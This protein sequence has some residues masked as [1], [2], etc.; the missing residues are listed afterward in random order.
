[1]A[2]ASRKGQF[3]LDGKLYKLAVNNGAHALHGGLKGFD[4]VVWGAKEMSTSDGVRLDLVYTS[5]DGEEGYPGT[6]TAT[7]SYTLLN[8]RKRA[9]DRL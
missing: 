4:K 6:L 2:I 5:K 9:E 1:M 8:E 7:V 3:T